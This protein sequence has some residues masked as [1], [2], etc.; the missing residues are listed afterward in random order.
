MHRRRPVASTRVMC[1]NT[2][3]QPGSG[4]VVSVASHL[5]GPQIAAMIECFKQGRWSGDRT[6]GF[7]AA[8]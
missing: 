6:P 3:T 1:A 2:A 4:R 7:T 5:V 8:V